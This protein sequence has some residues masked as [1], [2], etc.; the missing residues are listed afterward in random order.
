[1][2]R[3]EYALYILRYS[4]NSPSRKKKKSKVKIELLTKEPDLRNVEELVVKSNDKEKNPSDSDR[5]SPALSASSSSTRKTDAERRFEEVHK[6]RVCFT[7]C[8]CILF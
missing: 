8:I 6:K 4:N 3:S 2:S 7:D 5:N 1:M